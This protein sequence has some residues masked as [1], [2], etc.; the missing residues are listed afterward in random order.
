MSCNTHNQF[1]DIGRKG[2]ASIMALAAL[3]I[4]AVISATMATQGFMEFR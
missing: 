3:V 4:L 2:V 1:H